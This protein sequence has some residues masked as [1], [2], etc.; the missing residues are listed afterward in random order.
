MSDNLRN[1]EDFKS[2]AKHTAQVRIPSNEK[3]YQNR[4]GR[5]ISSLRRAFSKEE[6]IDIIQ[7]GDPQT[8]REVSRYYLRFCGE[9]AQMIDY[10]SSKLF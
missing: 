10:R 8:I 6:L 7:A 2:F 9:Y 1:I 3:S 5:S 4:Y